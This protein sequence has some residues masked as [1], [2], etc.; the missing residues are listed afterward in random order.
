MAVPTPTV[1]ANPVRFSQ[2]GNLV[3][4]WVPTMANYQ[5]PTSAEISAGFDYTS[6]IPK[7][8]ASGFETSSTTIASNDIKSGLE[9]P[10]ADGQSISNTPTVNFK[11]SSTTVTNSPSATFH[12]GLN[13]YICLTDAPSL[14]T[15]GALMDIWPV[16]VGSASKTWSGEAFVVVSFNPSAVPAY[17]VAVPTV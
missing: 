2:T 7:D 3:F 9:L 12:Y 8:G 14:S 13:G 11:R 5:S 10:L 16:T 15:A 1:V 4:I 6:W 17:N